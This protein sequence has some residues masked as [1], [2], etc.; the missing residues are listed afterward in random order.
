MT[1]A[2]ESEIPVKVSFL[3][4]EETIK[5]YNE[6]YYIFNDD[7][8]LENLAVLNIAINTTIDND[9]YEIYIQGINIFE[10]DGEGSYTVNWG[11]SNLQYFDADISPLVEETARK[12]IKDVIEDILTKF[13]EDTKDERI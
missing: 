7:V 6:K 12:V 2:T 8:S 5:I 10:S 13:V 3:D 9:D 1:Q 4:D 11:M